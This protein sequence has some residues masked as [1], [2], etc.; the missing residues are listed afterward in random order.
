MC[1][2]EQKT[3]REA[4]NILVGSWIVGGEIDSQLGGSALGRVLGSGGSGAGRFCGVLY[5]I[6]IVSGASREPR[7][8]E[9]QV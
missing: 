4:H 8:R 6:H 2:H 1:L 9:L 3:Q 7:A 5:Q